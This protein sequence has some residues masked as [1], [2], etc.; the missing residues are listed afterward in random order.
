[1]HVSDPLMLFLGSSAAVALA[2]AAAFAMHPSR[3]RHTG[4]LAAALVLSACE[5]I[6]FAASAAAL[7]PEDT[8]V[9]Q[10][11]RMVV[12]ACIPG[13]W[14]FF[15]LVYARANYRD[16]LRRWGAP[17]AVVAA[18]PVAVVAVGWGA[19]IES[20]NPEEGRAYWTMTPGPPAVL[21]AVFCILAHVLVLAGLERTLR[22][23][24]GLVRWRIKF[25]IAGVLVL[26]AVRIYV[27][28]QFLLQR[29]LDPAR[30]PLLATGL[31]CGC[32]L[33]IAS[34][35][36]AQRGS[37]DL[38]VSTDLMFGSAAA[39]VVAAYLVA[40]GVFAGA[41][42]AG[43]ESGPRWLAAA[44]AI[45]A[46]VALV[47]VLLSDRVRVTL[48]R[49]ITRHFRRPS[50]DYRLLWRLFAA[51]TRHAMEP[52]EL[53]RAV[54]NL[55]A[56]TFEALSVS[57]WLLDGK[58]D[59]RLCASTTCRADG[60]L[61][62]P[63]AAVPEDVVREW[64][65]VTEPVDLDRASAA[66]SR[67][68]LGW[69]PS[70]FAEGGHRY[71]MPL[72]AEG[73][74]CGMLT[75]GDRVHGL[76]MSSEELDLFQTLAEQTASR[77]LSLRM[78]ERLLVAKQMEAFQMMST[79]LVH[80]LKNTTSSLSLTLQNLKQHFEDP[81]FR[82]D[83]ERSI[84]AGVRKMNDVVA[85]LG[86]L[87]RGLELQPEDV[88][89]SAWVTE[90]LRHLDAETA[91]RVMWTPKASAR[92]RMDPRQM[93]G[94]LLNL[95][96][97]ARDASAPGTPI[98]VDAQTEQ[99]AG[100]LSVRDHGCGMTQEFVAGRLFRPFQTTKKDGMGIGLFQSRTIVEAHGG[101][102]DVESEPGRGTVFR[103]RIPVGGRT[104]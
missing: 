97:N 37:L 51:R 99:D 64:S 93:Q 7:L 45:P 19:L 1:M 101:R 22:E 68:V 81:A 53:A 40:I 49:S 4:I 87:R 55:V 83:A 3:A 21:L 42:S 33:L 12:T 65:R 6:L 35:R 16:G 94:V 15:S 8:L 74:V 89:V 61:H 28:G 17:G 5:C 36:R 39:L 13:A 18:L 91:S 71:A 104:T 90:T 73:R 24:R 82:K 103:V 100:V 58:H 66:W 86:A 9:L 30:G 48:R 46:F 44:L 63:P 56:E 11:L 98:E 23:A 102:M 32:A 92:W 62:A 27:D 29:V 52:D 57:L 59:L 76:A 75:L 25:V 31:I 14:I 95:V 2:T 84:S 54:T 80:D 85:R 67:F 78:S 60:G 43:G 26:L 70:H 10:K 72:I 20:V 69:T 77:V 38:Y 96:L 47:L 34:L 41:G 50:F 79:F 88:D